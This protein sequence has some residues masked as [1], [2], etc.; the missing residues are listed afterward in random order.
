MNDIV[1]NW[2]K[3][4]HRLT[5]A[6]L[7]A[8]F[9]A[10]GTIAVPVVAAQAFPPPPAAA[11]EPL[12]P[13][14][15]PAPAPMAAMIPMVALAP[16]L[17]PS[18]TAAPLPA[19]TAPVAPPA[20]PPAPPSPW[21]DYEFL[22]QDPADSLYKLG[23]AALREDFQRAVELFSRI[24]ELHPTSGYIA[25]AYYFEAFALSR[26][27]GMTNLRT[28]DL[29]L[30]EHLSSFPDHRTR[31]DAAALQARV[32]AQLAQGGDPGSAQAIGVAA[33][34]A[35]GGSGR[36][37]ISVSPQTGAIV[38]SG[39]GGGRAPYPPIAGGI[40]SSTGT[41]V[42]PPS[43]APESPAVPRVGAGVYSGRTPAMGG[44]P[45]RYA[46]QV[47]PGCE[48]DEV[49]IAALS[50]LQSIDPEQA[51]PALQR[52]ME[53]NDACA[54]EL[55]RHALFIL[56][57]NESPEARAVILR[58]AREDHDPSVRE[59]AI[60]WLSRVDS[61]AALEVLSQILRDSAQARFHETAIV[62]IGQRNDS[63]SETLLREYAARSSGNAGVRAS[64]I[65]LL[66]RVGSKENSDFL[67]SLYGREQ[68][69]A[70]K[71]QIMAALA[72]PNEPDNAPW[73]LERALD[74]NENS[75]LRVQ[76]LFL[77]GRAGTPLTTLLGLYDRVD[78]REMKEQLLHAYARSPEP[79]ALD[80][81]I[82]VARTEKDLHL[83]TSAVR[84]L[85]QSREP[86]A[87]AALMEI[88]GG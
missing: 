35:G 85:G 79:E 44:P 62:A 36:G 84:W 49:R 1:F 47:Q 57:R 77:A 71:E 43:R 56:S 34:S 80:K 17:P 59:G 7:A 15:P 58:L 37:G 88:I 28:A 83:R 22:P 27:G 68:S 32:R 39:G 25:D 53:R 12:E 73:L 52:I 87:L 9:A 61:P 30:T 10:N 75:H 24:R 33:G 41:M 29:R 86:R 16:S 14:A 74:E 20:A 50:A 6:M 60:F 51:L 13:P 64:A 69:V 54:T 70:M 8:L 38:S 66:G 23:I 11:P 31:T 26:L 78:S 72:R 5:I 82:A 55:R 42:P 18:P 81:L 63:Q 21:L 3:T 67:R 45:P 46:G 40:G 2:R 4:M 65:H 76:A 48:E 19:L